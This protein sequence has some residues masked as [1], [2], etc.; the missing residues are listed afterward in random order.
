MS[1]GAAVRACEKIQQWKW[2]TH[3]LRSLDK[4][5]MVCAFA[6]ASCEKEHRYSDVGILLADLMQLSGASLIEYMNDGCGIRPSQSS[7]ATSLLCYHDV[8]F[9]TV[10][11]MFTRSVHVHLAAKIVEAAEDVLHE[12]SPRQERMHDALLE[13]VSCLGPVITRDIVQ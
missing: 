4:D 6:I 11:H 2:A 8:W 1:Y 12:P 7:L 3:L 13:D 9:G 10:S 5:A